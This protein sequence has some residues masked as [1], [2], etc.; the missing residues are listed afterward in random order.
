MKKILTGFVV[1]FAALIMVTTLLTRTNVSAEENPLYLEAGIEEVE[2]FAAEYGVDIFTAAAI[3]R[4]LNDEDNVYTAEELLAL[5]A[6]VLF[7]LVLESIP[8]RGSWFTKTALDADLKRQ[9]EAYM[10][11]Y[12]FNPGQALKIALLV[13]AGE[14]LTTLLA[15]PVEDLQAAYQAA[16]EAGSIETFS[17]HAGAMR[18]NS[19]HA[20]AMRAASGYAGAMR[21]SS[22]PHGP[23]LNPANDCPNEPLPESS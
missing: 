18:A 15:L 11:D 14:D 6:D 16:K 5:D 12:D 20:G 22:G 23:H 21:S 17:G 9:V 19:N 13:N 10:T 2:A 7:A 1:G 8:A 4:M 3:V